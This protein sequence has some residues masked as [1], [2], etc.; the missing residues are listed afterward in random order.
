MPRILPA[1][2]DA[3]VVEGTK[4]RIRSITGATTRLRKSFG[5]D[6]AV[7]DWRTLSWDAQAGVWRADRCTPTA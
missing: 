2:G 1:L 3:V 5:G 6:E 7:V 4:Y